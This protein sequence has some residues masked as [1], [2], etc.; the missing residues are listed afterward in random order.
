MPGLN[1][2]GPEGQGPRTGR[3]MGNCK[4][5]KGSDETQK[6]IS[7]T[8]EGM[9]SRSANFTGRGQG[10]GRGFGG[11]RGWGRG[12]WSRGRRFYPEPY[13]QAQDNTR[14]PI[15]SVSPWFTTFKPEEEVKY[16]EET[17][18]GMKK[19]IESIEKRLGELQENNKK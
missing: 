10:R 8:D 12:G 17:L 7:S 6:N 5:R 4:P 18:I 14:A 19:E 16:L 9:D 11:G 3:Q 13:N 1:S 15:T 2:T